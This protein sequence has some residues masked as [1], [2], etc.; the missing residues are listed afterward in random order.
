M[1]FSCSQSA[2]FYFANLA[3]H[4]AHVKL[5]LP[6]PLVKNKMSP[7]LCLQQKW[8][9]LNLYF[10]YF[11][12]S[13]FYFG[14]SCMCTFQSQ[15]CGDTSTFRIGFL[16]FNWFGDIYRY[17]IVVNEMCDS[18]VNI[19]FGAPQVIV[20]VN[21]IVVSISQLAVIAILKEAESEVNLLWVFIQW[22]LFESNH[23]WCF[24]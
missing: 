22:L 5:G 9:R 3:H 20:L 17:W 14:T 19:F 8:G 23:W 1:D 24:F 11:C 13:Q 12:N 16:F 15:L 18:C 4:E 10:L 7:Y 6:R 2:K 21:N